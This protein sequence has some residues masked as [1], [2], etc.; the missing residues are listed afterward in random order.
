[1]EAQ[2]PAPRP[3]APQADPFVAYN[4]GAAS[5]NP[6]GTSPREP[7]DLYIDAVHFIPDNASIIK[8]GL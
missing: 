2:K 4:A 6:P 5:S 3:T 7:F 1:M 8:V